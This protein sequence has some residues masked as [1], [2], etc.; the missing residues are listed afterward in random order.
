LFSGLLERIT[1]MKRL[2]S[3]HAPNSVQV[4][5]KVP[6]TSQPRPPGRGH[7][8]WR[9]TAQHQPPSRSLYL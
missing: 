9:D 4:N 8:A 2:S 6:I 7:H 3:K 5:P 1:F